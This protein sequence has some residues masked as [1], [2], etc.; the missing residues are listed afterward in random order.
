MSP[1]S[2]EA[3]ARIG[4]TMAIFSQ[5]PWETANES[6]ER[7]RSLFQKHH[8]RTAPPILT[9][10]MV[11]CDED[12][13]RAEELARKHIAGYL[14]TVFEHYELMSEHFKTAKG[15]ATYGEAVDLLRDVGLEK[16]AD[17]YV[18]VQAWGTPDQVVEKLR[19]RREIIGDF[20]FNGCFRFAGIPFDA[21]LR[22]MELYAEH[23]I[24]ALRND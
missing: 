4:G 6:I 13:G 10:D 22:S 20:D 17:M 11:V 5:A 1:D 2:V 18:D 24:P 12:A 3:A 15:Y 9:T 21:T 19:K 16:V 8:G 14:V 23:V 7:Y